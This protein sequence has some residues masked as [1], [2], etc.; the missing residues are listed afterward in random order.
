MEGTGTRQT[1]RLNHR[2][3]PPADAR[4]GAPATRSIPPLS[5][6]ADV[7]GHRTLGRTGLQVSRI[8]LG[9]GGHSCLGRTQG[10][11]EAESVRV[12]QR[13]IE[14]GINLF[15]TSGRNGTERIIGRGIRGHDRDAL[16]L[17]TKRTVSE[18]GVL[19]S[20]AQFAA[21][22]DESLQLLDTPYVDIMHFHGVAPGEYDYVVAELL[23]VM[24]RFRAQ[25]KV[26]YIGL[27]EIFDKDR[28]HAMLRRALADDYWDVV[29]VGFNMVNQSA[30][31]RV[32]IAA[33]EK[34]IG[35]LGMFAVRR[36]LAS[37]EAFRQALHELVSAGELAP[38]FEIDASIERLC[39]DAGQRGALA[40][41]AYRYCRDER[42]MHSVLVGTGDI[43]HLEQNVATFLQPP[44]PASTRRFIAETFGHITDFS[45]N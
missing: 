10:K 44:L 17:S 23:P 33:R 39:T 16:V 21:A 32:L 41:I 8:G 9:G 28:D 26:R 38:D 1:M 34:D 22:L 18:A 12:V 45:G 2:N 5:A 25:G 14:L 20:A 36:A 24:E 27:T 7:P 35:I 11:T 30:R 3:P 37:A 29:M 13:A 43:G 6:R 4:P 31:E 19:N 15:D 42:G 40:D